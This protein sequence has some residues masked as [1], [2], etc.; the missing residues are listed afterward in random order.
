ML[1]TVFTK[2]IMPKLHATVKIVQFSK[3]ENYAP[4]FTI[5]SGTAWC[6]VS[7]GLPDAYFLRD[8]M[9]KPLANQLNVKT[10][11][12]SHACRT[13]TYLCHHRNYPNI[14]SVDK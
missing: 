14:M 2:K 11:C 13:N 8:C 9:V 10:G 5:F 12:Y 1:Y 7:Q 4:N 6:V 3:G